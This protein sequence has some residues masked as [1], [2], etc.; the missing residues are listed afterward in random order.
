MSERFEVKYKTCKKKLIEWGPNKKLA[1]Y[2]FLKIKAE[3]LSDKDEW[4]PKYEK[5]I[6][7]YLINDIKEFN[8]DAVILMLTELELVAKIMKQRQCLLM[9]LY[10]GGAKKSRDL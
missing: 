3:I 9:P 1:L 2:S 7:K 10:L 4:K 6:D 5:E 8:P